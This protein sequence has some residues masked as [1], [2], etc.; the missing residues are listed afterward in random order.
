MKYLLLSI[1]F[2]LFSMCGRKTVGDFHGLKWGDS[3]AQ[4]KK[5]EGKLPVDTS[6]ENLYVYSPKDINGVPVQLGYI[7]V[8]DQLASATYIP[9]DATA[10]K[11]KIKKTYLYIGDSL[12][13]KF[14]ASKDSVMEE[15]SKFKRTWHTSSSNIYLYYY[16][17]SFML[18]INSK[19][20]EPLIDMSPES[21]ETPG[22][23]I[24]IEMK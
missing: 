23:S 20:L 10:M 11:S 8:D 2:L 22:D 6:E 1:P 7:F 19:R 17:E 21:K 15:G 9:M 13:K 5:I 4:V 24:K 14:G 18:S 3:K 12:T 16:N